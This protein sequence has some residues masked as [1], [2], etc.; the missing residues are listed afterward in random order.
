MF[1]RNVNLFENE[2]TRL[3]CTLVGKYLDTIR[4]RLCNFFWVVDKE[5]TYHLG[6]KLHDLLISPGQ[7]FMEKRDSSLI[8][9]IQI[10]N[11]YLLSVIKPVETHFLLS[12]CTFKTKQNKKKKATYVL[13]RLTNENIYT[14]YTCI[15]FS[16]HFCHH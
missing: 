2:S 1:I 7:K 16:A 12:M 13:L 6:K 8:S 3:T 15:L 11:R 10:S 5:K 4:T 9:T 14:F